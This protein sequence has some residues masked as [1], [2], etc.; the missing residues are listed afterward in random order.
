MRAGADYAGVLEET[1]ACFA[2]KPENILAWLGPAIGPEA[3]E[4]GPEVRDAFMAKDRKR[5]TL[6]PGGEKY[7]AD[8]YQLARQR[9]QMS[10]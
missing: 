1:V 10:A 5:K 3:F 7:F 4:V 6:S 2:D 9:W 8:I